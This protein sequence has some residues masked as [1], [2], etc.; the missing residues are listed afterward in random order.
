MKKMPSLFIREFENHKVI[1]CLNEINPGCEWVINGEGTATEKLD[2]TCCLIE[3][4]KIYA[5][6]DFKKGR[7]LPEGAIPC[8]TKADPITG[9][10]PHWVLCTDQPQY[11]Y[12][13]K[14]FEKMKDNLI[15][16]A[17]VILM[18]HMS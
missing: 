4:D 12:H 6:Y 5:R 15:C 11:K 14:A 13:I 7:K 18:V 17:E 8:Q 10:F 9:H 2:G 3:G 1:K 16:I